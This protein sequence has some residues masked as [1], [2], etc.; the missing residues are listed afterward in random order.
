MVSGYSYMTSELEISF[1]ANP[2]SSVA[3]SPENLL[4]VLK[5]KRMEQLLLANVI[6]FA[7]SQSNLN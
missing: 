1:S 5:D 4:S 3:P 2:Y 7:S 6:F